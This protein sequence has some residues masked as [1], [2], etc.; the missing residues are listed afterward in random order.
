MSFTGE[1]IALE[2]K[3]STW[4]A[5]KVKFFGK[6]FSEPVVPYVALHLLNGEGEIATLG[7]P[8]MRRH[9]GVLVLQIFA[10]ENSPTGDAQIRT[11]ADQLELLFINANSRL[12][13]S[14]TE[15]I[16]FDQPS[17]SAPLILNGWMQ[18]NLSVDYARSIVS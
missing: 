1:Q 17:L 10:K 12:T 8:H 9:I 13:I 6:P 3:F 4:T 15:F 11:L 18:R 2:G 5:S 16:D 7:I 14:A